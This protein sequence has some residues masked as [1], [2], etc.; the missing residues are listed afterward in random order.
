MVPLNKDLTIY[1]GKT[2]EFPIK[3]ESEPIVYKAI[4]AITQAAPVKITAVGH[5]LPS[6]WRAAVICA[7]GMQQ[8]NSLN[9][10]PQDSD[11][12]VVT[13]IDDDNVE[14][15]EVSSACYRPY[16]SGGYLQYY[17]PKDLTGY[18]AEMKVKDAV[19][20]NTL[21]TLSSAIN[22]GIFIDN[23]T[24][25]IKLVLTAAQTAALV[26]STGVYDLELTSPGGVV[27]ALLYGNVTVTPEIT[28]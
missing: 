16:T 27:T 21:L 24:K 15:N 18:S 11:Y 28:V 14:F 6:G 22:G 13:R 25:T 4:T 26:W 23:P 10:P 3:W 17:T 2:F 8:I 9:A 7:K 12:H 1:Q 5:G 19:G 20:G